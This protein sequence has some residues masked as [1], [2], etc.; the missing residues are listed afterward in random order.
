MHNPEAFFDAAVIIRQL[1]NALQGVSGLEIQRAAY[2]ACLLALYEGQPVA[3]WGHRF[4]RTEFGTPYS[5]GINDAVSTLLSSQRLIE[6][7]RRFYLTN[8][9]ADLIALLE[10]MRNFRE[11]Q[12]YLSAACASVLAVPPATFTDSL[13]N[14]PTV[15]R[16]F[17]REKGGGLLE[18][19]ALKLLYEQFEALTL[20]LN[21]ETADLLTPSVVWLTYTAEQGTE[22]KG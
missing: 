17:Q 7:E 10:A 18:G 14:E 22:D 20:A 5:A 6:K 21:R 2:L 4:A 12:K 15:R 9:G 13:D 8:S 3:D 19:P 1:Q 11:R 16:A